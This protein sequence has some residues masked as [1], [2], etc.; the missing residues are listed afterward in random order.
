MWNIY[1]NKFRMKIFKEKVTYG[2]NEAR[3]CGIFFLLNFE[4]QLIIISSGV[5]AFISSFIWSSL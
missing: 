4:I 2:E 1:H 3:H 5:S